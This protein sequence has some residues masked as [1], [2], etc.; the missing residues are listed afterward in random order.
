MESFERSDLKEQLADFV[1][2]EQTGYTSLYQS[3]SG[4]FLSVSPEFGRFLYSCVRA[5]RPQVAVEF[6]SSMGISAIYTAC[7]LRD[8]GGGK[9]IGTELEASKVQR[10]RANVEAAGLT[11]LVEFRIGDALE[12]LKNIEGQ[13]DLVLMDGAFILYLPV[14]KLLEP[15][16]R[17]GALIIGENA[18]EDAGG[19][20]DY[21]R[22]P[23]NGY[24]SQ[25]IPFQEGRGNEFTVVTR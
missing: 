21:V 19:Y 12:T 6:G 18:I 22:N 24:L 14:L 11:G 4:N 10:A 25:P 7:A 8:N 3:L 1:L 23:A 15:R 2:R 9:L 20:L 16:L 5:C 17:T 13:I